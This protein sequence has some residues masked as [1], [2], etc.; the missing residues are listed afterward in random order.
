MSGIDWEW[1][2]FLHRQRRMGLAEVYRL[3]DEARARLG[4]PSGQWDREWA[5]W[6]RQE[7]IR[8]YYRWSLLVNHRINGHTAASASAA[9]AARLA[10]GGAF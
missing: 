6:L 4:L 2:D 1:S 10:E 7:R 8:D 5:E 9:V 3:A